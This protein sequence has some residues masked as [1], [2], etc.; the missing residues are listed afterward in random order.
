MLQTL[1]LSLVSSFISASFHFA[2]QWAPLSGL[3]SWTALQSNCLFLVW[4]ILNLSFPVLGFELMY[5]T[6]QQQLLFFSQPSQKDFMLSARAVLASYCWICKPVLRNWQPAC[7]FTWF[8]M[9]VILCFSRRYRPNYLKYCSQHLFCLFGSYYANFAS[10]QSLAKSS[11]KFIVFSTLRTLE[12][13]K[14]TQNKGAFQDKVKIMRYM[15]GVSMWF[16]C[17]MCLFSGD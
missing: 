8:Y 13:Q 17:D 9:K 2:H 10:C 15:K 6:K 3:V 16:S 14:Y 1:P 4:P 7:L 12:L 11:Y 5:N